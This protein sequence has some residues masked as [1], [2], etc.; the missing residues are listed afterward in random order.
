MEAPSENKGRLA[1][2]FEGFTH[3]PSKDLFD[4]IAGSMDEAPGALGGTLG[5][6]THGP[7]PAVWNRIAQ[8]MHP[9][10]GYRIVWISAIASLLFLAGYGAYRLLPNDAAAL[11]GVPAGTH[12]PAQNLPSA[13]S[14]AIAQAGT[15]AS[16][17]VGSGTESAS[18]NPSHD[19][20]GFPAKVRA[21][22]PTIG[23]TAARPIAPKPG[24]NKAPKS[25]PVNPLA[26]FFPSYPL[27]S[28]DDAL[29]FGTGIRLAPLGEGQ[30]NIVPANENKDLH[31]EVIPA[32]DSLAPPVQQ[33]MEEEY[34][35]EIEIP[36][37]NEAEGAWGFRVGANLSQGG[38]MATDEANFCDSYWFN[39]GPEQNA[40]L[41]G[42]ES[43]DFNTPLLAGFALDIPL[44]K[45]LHLLPGLQYTLL[46]SILSHDNGTQITRQYLGLN[47]SASYDV[48][49]GKRSSAY[50]LLG[51][52]ADMGIAADTKIIPGSN[53]GYQA[54]KAGN[55]IS[56]LAGAGVNYMLTQ[57]IGFYAQG[58]ANCYIFQ[59]QA[60]L[61][62][63]KAL[64]PGAQVGIKVRM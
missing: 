34:F 63:Q 1:G 3:E 29:N 46:K 26:P 45:R 24:S 54:P 2:K 62:S 50:V 6:L 21:S 16:A 25:S 60:N 17:Q 14:K 4:R 8:R 47:V 15:D 37:G 41:G 28:F 49:K 33:P 7:K 57:H 10:H 35:P 52:Q 39:I 51:T 38:S 61:F 56:T 11:V 58:Q 31:P 44:G 43:E 22:Q 23:G 59:T 64:W 30:Q 5:A 40:S 20:S 48:V 55:Q 12:G 19:L 27:I 18:M 32:K 9:W 13:P 42:G 36:K 53:S